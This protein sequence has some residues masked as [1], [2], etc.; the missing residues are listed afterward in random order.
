MLPKLIL[1][2]DC[3]HL[4]L[5]GSDLSPGNQSGWQIV[6][7]G[8]LN[9]LYSQLALSW[10]DFIMVHQKYLGWGAAAMAALSLSHVSASYV[11][12][13]APGPAAGALD[14]TAGQSHEVGPSLSDGRTWTMGTPLD[15]A[16]LARFLEQHDWAAASEETRRLV[17]EAV[18]RREAVTIGHD[19]LPDRALAKIT[20][21]DLQQLDVL[22]VARSQGQYGFSVQQR[23][24]GEALDYAHLKQDPKHWV[25]FTKHLGWQPVLKVAED[26]ANVGPSRASGASGA[27]GASNSASQPQGA[28][29]RPIQATADFDNQPIGPDSETFMGSTLLD[30]VAQCKL[31]Q[32]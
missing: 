23:L 6:G 29:P 27:S 25:N 26:T 8:F 19:W 15:T 1:G 4:L 28:W 16:A 11:A 2:E 31:Q 18:E 9:R 13:Q 12:A 10:P 24:W 32:G 7:L 22:W 20:C 5:P 21:A 3:L 30:R 17:F 14:P